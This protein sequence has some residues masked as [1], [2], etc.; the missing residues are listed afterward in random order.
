MPGFLLVIVV[1]GIYDMKSQKIIISA[2]DIVEIIENENEDNYCQYLFNGKPINELTNIES[3]TSIREKENELISAIVNNFIRDQF[4]NTLILTGAGASIIG[5]DKKYEGYSGKTVG[6]LTK[7]ID[8]YLK[9]TTSVYS[10]EELSKIINYFSDHK[11]YNL[12]EVNIED[13][14]SKAESAKD[15]LNLDIDT[16]FNKTIEEIEKQIMQQCNIPLSKAYA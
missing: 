11:E 6:G 5:F 12:N 16:K 10:L 15:Y 3:E 1:K 8:D 2:I 14:L 4:E 13:L 9:E 7:V